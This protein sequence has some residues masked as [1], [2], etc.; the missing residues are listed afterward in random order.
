MKAIYSSLLLWMLLIA[1]LFIQDFRSSYKTAACDNYGEEDTIPSV[2]SQS[3]ENNTETAELSEMKDSGEV[4][5][6]LNPVTDLALVALKKTKCAGCH[7]GSL[8]S[9]KPG[10]L[11]I[12]DLD[13]E[14]WYLKFETEH[15]PGFT[16]R[17]KE[18]SVIPEAD[19]KVLLKFI[20]CQEGRDCELDS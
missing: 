5:T 13:D 9:A 18:E 15:H 2:S 16:R 11:A 19:K 10:A 7:T 8:A 4:G 3:A 6:P 20:D 1:F 17:I 14:P 12:F